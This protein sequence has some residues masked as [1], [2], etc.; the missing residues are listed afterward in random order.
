MS[1]LEKILLTSA[2]TIVGGVVVFVTGQL[3]GKF[4]IEPIHELRKVIG[5]VRFM[6][7][8]H[9]PTINTP[10]GRSDKTSES[11]YGALMKCS[12]DLL[13]RAEAI[14]LHRFLS[15]ASFRFV[16]DKRALADA[17]MNLRGLSTYIHER[18]EEANMNLNEI[19]RRIEIIEKKLR[20]RSHAED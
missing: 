6:L 18:G 1:D 19:Q 10:S 16:P 5:E 11:T 14:P 13:V 20:I 7:A 3:L 2:L 12:A 4:V 15:W 8:F 17:A 9:A